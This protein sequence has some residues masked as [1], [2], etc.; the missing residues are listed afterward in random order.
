MGARV[1]MTQFTSKQGQYLAYIHLYGLADWPA[2]VVGIL[3]TALIP[4]A[5]VVTEWPREG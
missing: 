4:I 2:G 3:L 5:L 1:E